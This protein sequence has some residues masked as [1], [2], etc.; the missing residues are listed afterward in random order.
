MAPL[1]YFS[2]FLFVVTV[3]CT[4]AREEQQKPLEPQPVTQKSTL[5]NVEEPPPPAPPAPAKPEEEPSGSPLGSAHQSIERA[6]KKM[7]E[8]IKLVRQLQAGDQVYDCRNSRQ[9]QQAFQNLKLFFGTDNLH[10]DEYTFWFVA[11]DDTKV[12]LNENDGILRDC[13][14]GMFKSFKQVTTIQ[15]NGEHLIRTEFYVNPSSGEL[16]VHRY[17]D[18]KRINAN[19][20]LKSR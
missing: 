5:K 11:N 6:G 7:S 3:A 17:R 13:T 10:Y 4:T 2:L 15:R 14:I 1:K 8:T 12:G 19:Y 18:R 9:R 16:M 20:R